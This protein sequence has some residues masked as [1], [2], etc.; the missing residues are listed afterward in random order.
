VGVVA[1]ATVTTAFG[2]EVGRYAEMEDLYV[3]PEHRR[4][5]WATQLVDA[6]IDWWRRRGCAELEVVVTREGQRAHRLVE[7]Y[8]ASRS[9]GPEARSRP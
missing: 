4:Q 6:A 7:W 8:G 9:P 1:V 5:G 3:L 2:F